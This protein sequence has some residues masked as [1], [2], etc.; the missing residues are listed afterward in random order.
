MNEAA[1]KFEEAMNTNDSNRHQAI[2]KFMDTAIKLSKEISEKAVK[3][4][5]SVTGT[6]RQFMLD[7]IRMML[8]K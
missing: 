4:P 3:D 5:A 8:S 2:S 1:K 6:E 7:V